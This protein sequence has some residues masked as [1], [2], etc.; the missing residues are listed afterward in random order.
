MAVLVEDD[1]LGVR[2]NEAAQAYQE[3][4]GV[5]YGPGIALTLVQDVVGAHGGTVL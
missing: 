2:V 5:M 1:G 3:Q 4:H